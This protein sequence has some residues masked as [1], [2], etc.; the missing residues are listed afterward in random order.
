MHTLIKDIAEI[1]Q[2]SPFKQHRVISATHTHTDCDRRR[3]AVEK[4]GLLDVQLCTCLVLN[5][6]LTLSRALLIRH[7]SSGHWCCRPTYSPGQWHGRRLTTCIPV[8]MI[9][10]MTLSFLGVRHIW[11]PKLWDIGYEETLLKYLFQNWMARLIWRFS[12]SV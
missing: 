7:N 1:T 2:S 5:I 11:L 4:N 3:V 10:P 8:L 6:T 12:W 9:R